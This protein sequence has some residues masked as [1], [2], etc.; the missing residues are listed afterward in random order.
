ML[1]NLKTLQDIENH[2]DNIRMNGKLSWEDAFQLVR[3]KMKVAATYEEPFH[4]G[5]C[6][7]CVK[8]KME[9]KGRLICSKCPIGI[10]T[11]Q[12]GCYGSPFYEAREAR[13][14]ERMRHLADFLDFIDELEVPDPLLPTGTKGSVVDSDGNFVGRGVLE[15]RDE[16]SSPYVYTV[17]WGTKEYGYSGRFFTA[18]KHLWE[19][20]E[21]GVGFQ[22]IPDPEPTKIKD[23]DLLPVGTKGT[24][25]TNEGKFSGRGEVETLSPDCTYPYNVSFTDS[26]GDLQSMS[27]SKGLRE[28]ADDTGDRFIPD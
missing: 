2:L 20:E 27:F 3:H 5:S 10:K 14:S 4:S 13:G 23:S 15:A 16:P 21:Q 24:I 9:N 26:D 17:N 18:T 25:L 7:F 19:Y 1:D 28:Y 8:I 11:G 6:A 22:F 12:G